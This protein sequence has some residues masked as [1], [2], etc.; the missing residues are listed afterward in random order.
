MTYLTYG[1]EVS[2]TGTPHLQGYL[3]W[4]TSI[5]LVALKKRLG[6]PEIH[7]EARIGT[8]QQAIDY[9]HK[10]GDFVEYGVRKK[11]RV[12]AL[13]TTKNK[14]LAFKDILAEGGL[15]SL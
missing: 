12:V 6:I 14:M 2:S 11:G 15:V 9:C 7:L 10:D 3:E 8:Q 5:S 1:K 4:F 13:P